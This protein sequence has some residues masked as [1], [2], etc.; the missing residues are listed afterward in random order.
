MFQGRFDH[1]ID[2]KGRLSV[3]R[4]FRSELEG[5]GENPPMLLIQ[6]DHIALFPRERWN[7]K[8]Q[9][10]TTMDEWDPNGQRLR[11]LYGANSQAAPIDPQGRILL[12]AW[13]RDQAGLEGKAIVSGAL[14][15]VE[16][17]SPA[18]FEQQ[19]A[20]TLANLDEIQRMVDSAH[21][22]TR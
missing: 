15:Y 10:L 11:R 16:L 22:S 2:D 18:R 6:P 17:W 7:A 4:A 3:P 1:T 5:T 21:R 13:M 19:L 14:D 20:S 8:L 12:P 9:R